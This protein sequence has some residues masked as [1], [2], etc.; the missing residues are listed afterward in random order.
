MIRSFRSKALRRFWIRNDSSG[1]RPDW[2]T[3]VTRLLNRLDLAL[4]PED[5]D[6]PGSGFHSLS[7]DMKGRFALTVSRNWRITFA[8]DGQDAI[9][10]DLEDYH[11]R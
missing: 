8:F 11:G 7:G 5:L 3:K 2:L 6:A 10:V 4:Q 9:E 1:I